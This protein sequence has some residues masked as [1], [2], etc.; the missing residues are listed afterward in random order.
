M[1][2]EDDDDDDDENYNDDNHVNDYDNQ[3]LKPKR[4]IR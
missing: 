1:K 3:K 2:S 4:N